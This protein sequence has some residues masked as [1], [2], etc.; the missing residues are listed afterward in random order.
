MADFNTGVIDLSIENT[1]DNVIMGSGDTMT[2]SNS[3]TGGAANA[4]IVVTGNFTVAA[5]AVITLRNGVN[6][7]AGEVAVL[8]ITRDL[9][10]VAIVAGVGGTSGSAAGGS[11]AHPRGDYG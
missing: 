8:G 9:T 4:P 6:L 10:A 5:G 3:G 7:S 2:F 11:G 1:F